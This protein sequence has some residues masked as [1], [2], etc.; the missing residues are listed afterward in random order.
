MSCCLMQFK[1]QR[2]CVDAKV[3]GEEMSEGFGYAF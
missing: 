2:G 1:K 3:F